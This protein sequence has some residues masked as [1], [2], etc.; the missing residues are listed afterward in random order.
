MIRLLT[1]AALAA[2]L[3][4]CGTPTPYQSGDGASYGYREQAVEN[5]RYLVSFRGNTLTDRETVELFLLF[6]AAELT[7]ERGYDHFLVARR[8][9]DADRR[10]TGTTS[11]FGPH[12]HYRSR[13]GAHYRYYHPRFGWYGRHDPFWND[14]YLRE[15]TRY[16]AQAEIVLGRG[17]APD[18]PEAFDARQV[19]E[20]LGPR[21]TAPEPR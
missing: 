13:F 14:T 16:E 5:N 11:G 20:N 18:A 8:D 19:V 10:I 1:A 6:R 7:L 15:V 9:T 3:A 12:G 17:P 2:V 21:V 4:A